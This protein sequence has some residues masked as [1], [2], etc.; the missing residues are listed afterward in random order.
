[1]SSTAASDVDRL[2]ATGLDKAADRSPIN[3]NFASSF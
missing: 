1:V 3:P 2:Q